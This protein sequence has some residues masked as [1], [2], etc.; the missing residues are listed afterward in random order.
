M[1]LFVFHC[2]FPIF[3][4][5]C[6]VDTTAVLLL[7]LVGLDDDAK[8]VDDHHHDHEDVDDGDAVLLSLVGF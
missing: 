3:A 1:Y 6:Q 8:N 2:V 5:H 7:S 4:I